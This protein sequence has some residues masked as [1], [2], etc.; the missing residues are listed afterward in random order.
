MLH[1]ERNDSVKRTYAR[2]G[3]VADLNSDLIPSRTS[4]NMEDAVGIEQTVAFVAK[5]VPER[6]KRARI[7]P[8]E[9][10]YIAP[11]AEKYGDDVVKMR[12]DIKMNWKQ[13]GDT[14]LE[15]LVREYKAKAES[16]AE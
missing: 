10:E 2:A 7:S 16:E 9:I 4:R 11:L 12:R 15:R 3:L 8:G 1:I 13:L 5:D 6:P 14:A